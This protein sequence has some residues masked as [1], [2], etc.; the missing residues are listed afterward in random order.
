M[1]AVKQAEP[2]ITQL[3]PI[4]NKAWPDIVAVTSLIQELIAFAKQQENSK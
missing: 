2:L 1:A 4:V 3:L